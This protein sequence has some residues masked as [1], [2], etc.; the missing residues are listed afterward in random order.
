MIAEHVARF[1]EGLELAGELVRRLDI[2]NPVILRA[3]A[4]V[5]DARATSPLEAGVAAG[6]RLLANDLEDESRCGP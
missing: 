2:D 4:D 6:Y 1:C 3:A 5:T